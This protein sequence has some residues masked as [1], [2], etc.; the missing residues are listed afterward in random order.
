MIRHYP[1]YINII[2]GDKKLA[3]TKP[4]EH[5]IVVTL[6]HQNLSLNELPHYAITP[7]EMDTFLRT[8]AEDE[9]IAE[10]VGL[11]TCNRTEF[12]VTAQSVKNAA[13]AIV[14]PL[15]QRA[16]VSLES[17]RPGLDVIVDAEGV[18]HLFRLV[19][20]LESMVLGDAQIL[21]QVK[22]A[23]NKGKELGTVQKVF[24]FLFQNAFATAKR[25][26]N[27]TGLGKGRVSV[28]SLAVERAFNH[29]GDLSS[30]VVTVI[31]AGKMGRLTAKYLNEA[32]VKELRV[33]NRTLER[34]LELVNECGGK[35]YNFDELD[36]L[37]EESQLIISGTAA[38]NYLF[39]RERVDQAV[40]KQLVNR[41]YIDIALPP[42]IEPSVRSIEGVT[43]VDLEDLRNEARKNEYERSQEIKLAE[44]IVQEE[45]ERIGPWPLPFHIDKFA[46]QLGDLA[47]KVCTAEI[48]HV[49]EALP[50]LTEHQKGVI[51]HQMEKLA[52]RMI[53]GPRRNIRTHR[54]L[55]TCPN[56]VHCL[57]ELFA[58]DCNRRDKVTAEMA[59]K[60]QS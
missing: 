31:G 37:L 38:P 14:Y 43:L 48:D 17:L 32:G 56:A 54:A 29:F 5:F 2:I 41:L 16:G 45:L 6:N 52:E 26:R 44:E 46:S 55:R 39:T 59:N 11:S 13:H 12:Y 22:E 23:F 30:L 7:E 47:D 53:L 40:K 19:S 57:A 36:T 49:F 8:V 34:S 25:V 33:A 10:V 42:D 24:N 58:L 35:A 18:E 15:A 3:R 20:S 60:E 21:G 27:E 4:L 28:S 9:A 1:D 51:K 50:E